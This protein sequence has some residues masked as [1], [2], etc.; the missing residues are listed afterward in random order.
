MNTREM[1][2]QYKMA[3]WAQI[4]QERAASGLNIKEFCEQRGIA[5]Q[6][7]H[8]W[9]CKLRDAAA[10]QLA[11]AAEPGSQ[12]LVP[13]GWAQVAEEESPALE[14][15]GLTLRIGGAEIEVH[16]GFNEALLASVCR[17]LSQC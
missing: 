8:Y 2:T 3:Q 4:M 16:Q 10:R 1:A 15:Q 14:P 13:A 7:Y 6:T 11:T 5:R 12:G 9:Q 17:A